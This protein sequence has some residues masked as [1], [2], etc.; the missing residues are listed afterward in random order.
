MEICLFSKHPKETQDFYD[1]LLEKRQV[2]IEAA[3]HPGIAFQLF[4]ANE[5]SRRLDLDG[6]IWEYAETRKF[7]LQDVAVLLRTHAIDRLRIF[8]SFLG[9][10]SKEQHEEGPVHYSHRCEGILFEIYPLRKN[11][12]ATIELLVAVVNPIQKCAELGCSPLVGMRGTVFEDPDGRLV[13]IIDK[14][15]L[16]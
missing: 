11:H 1:C 8:C 15:R 13:Q 14:N 4:S 7:P 2:R 3:E 9:D 6:R 10:W 12:P 5:I 16:G